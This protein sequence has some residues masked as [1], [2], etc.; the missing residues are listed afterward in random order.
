MPVPKPIEFNRLVLEVSAQAK[1]SL[2]RKEVRGLV[3]DRLSLTDAE[4]QEMVP[5]GTQT[6]V[7]NRTNWS[8]SHLKNAGLLEYLGQGKSQITQ[9]G[10]LFLASHKGEIRWRDLKQVKSESEGSSD[11]TN[12]VVPDLEDI[13]PDEQMAQGY[14]QQ[15]EQLADEILDSI[16]GISPAA[17]ER[18][19]NRLLSAMGYGEIEREQG[20]SG[21]QGIDGIL[22]QDTLG[23]EKVYVQAKRYA[24]AQVSEHEILNFSGSL[25]LYGATKGVFITTSTFSQSARRAAQN[26]ALRGKFIRLIG[27]QELAQLMIRYGVGVVTEITY[28]VKKLDANYFAEV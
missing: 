18:L 3:A 16:K 23:L 11:K 26:I 8:I 13:T 6:L 21:D 25:D 28:E 5:T 12:D 17:F 1:T 4:L 9:Q 15:Q 20:Y 2:S 27:G 24:D 10:R 19:V 14:Q 7:E 22:N